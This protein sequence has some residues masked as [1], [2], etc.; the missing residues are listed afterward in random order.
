M[1]T[2]QVHNSH[3]LGVTRQHL[4]SRYHESILW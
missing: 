3:L 4:I 1:K 2:A